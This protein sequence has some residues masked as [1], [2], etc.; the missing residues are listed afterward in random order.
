MKRWHLWRAQGRD[1]LAQR[2]TRL[3][4]SRYLLIFKSRAILVVKGMIT[5]VNLRGAYSNSTI[6]IGAYLMR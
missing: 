5:A 4:F 3:S 6:S 1:L 2:K